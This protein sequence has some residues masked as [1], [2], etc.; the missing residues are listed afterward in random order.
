MSND[1]AAPPA[2][3][4]RANGKSGGRKTGGGS[5]KARRKAGR[6]GAVQALYQIDLT[7]TPVETVV[8]E[9]VAHRLGEEIDGAKFVAGDPQLFADI[10]RGAIHRR[11]EVDSVLTAA[12]DPRFPL[13]RLEL[14][15]R[16]ILRAGAYEIAV[17][18]DTHPRILISEYVDVA[19]AFFA[20]REP[21][22]VNGVLDHVARAL[23]AEDLARP[24][25]SR[26]P[27]EG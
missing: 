10:V 27:S 25:P 19:H 4:K 26:T 2:K 11:A 12:L 3:P 23:R 1:D 21:A 15:L 18:L 20:G 5:A 16:A 22:M 7:G 13:D 24:D 17:H 14:L 6:L 9:F 8:G